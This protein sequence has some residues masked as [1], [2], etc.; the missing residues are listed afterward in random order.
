MLGN[1]AGPKSGGFESGG[2]RGF[3]ALRCGGEVP[4]VFLRCFFFALPDFRGFSGTWFLK[5][6]LTFCTGP[7]LSVIW[8][9]LPLLIFDS[10]VASGS[11]S[12]AGSIF[13]DQVWISRKNQKIERKNFWPGLKPKK[14]V[15]FRVRRSD[16]LR[17]RTCRSRDLNPRPEFIRSGALPTKL[18]ADVDIS[19]LL[20]QNFS[21][22]V[23]T[24]N[25][26]KDFCGRGLMPLCAHS[27]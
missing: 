10:G 17:V 23:G 25:A 6:F 13:G 15:L 24:A 27:T 8:T 12:S 2:G 3:G 4:T 16:L 14:G 11:V 21:V 26:S 1:T 5:R 19:S 22:S 9:R 7:P 18:T 20:F